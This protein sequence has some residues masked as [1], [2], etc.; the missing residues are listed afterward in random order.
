MGIDNSDSRILSYR[1]HGCRAVIDGYLGVAGQV[2][3]GTGATTNGHWEAPGHQGRQ[4]VGESLVFLQK[5]IKKV[6]M[7][8]DNWLLLRLH[9]ILALRD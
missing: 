1:S 5:V 2:G 7:K 3:P 6:H 4:G 8:K 9:S